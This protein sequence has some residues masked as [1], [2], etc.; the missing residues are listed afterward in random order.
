MKIHRG[1]ECGPPPSSPR[2]ASS[3]LRAFFFDEGGAAAEVDPPLPP[4]LP[5]DFFFAAARRAKGRL[6]VAGSQAGDTVLLPSP[7]ADDAASELGGTTKAV[8]KGRMH[9][10]TAT[11]M[12]TRWIP[13][14]VMIPFAGRGLMQKWAGAEG[15]KLSGASG[16]RGLAEKKGNNHWVHATLPTPPSVAPCRVWWGCRGKRGSERPKRGLRKLETTAVNFSIEAACCC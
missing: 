7:V 2:L 3:P 9:T 13:A 12:L 14:R 11:A 10:N 8:A 16:S 1:N 4:L 6:R 15:K 5:A